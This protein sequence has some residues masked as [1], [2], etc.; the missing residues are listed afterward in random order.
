ML[1]LFS[2]VEVALG[3]IMLLCSLYFTTSLTDS[4]VN[5]NRGDCSTSAT[6]DIVVKKHFNILFIQI[7]P[8]NGIIPRIMGSDSPHEQSEDQKVCY[9]VLYRSLHP[10]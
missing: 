7:F 9:P 2:R 4:L 3:L 1:L 6:G 5:N 8:H 10:I